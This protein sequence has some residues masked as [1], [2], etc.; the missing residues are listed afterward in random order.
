MGRGCVRAL[1]GVACDERRDCVFYQA[2]IGEVINA[3]SVKDQLFE[4]YGTDDPVQVAELML[5]ELRVSVYGCVPSPPNVHCLRVHRPPDHATRCPLCTGRHSQ[6]SLVRGP[7]GVLRRCLRCCFVSRA[8]VFAVSCGVAC[9]SRLSLC[10][11]SDVVVVLAVVVA[12]GCLN[13]IPPMSV[14]L[15]FS[16]LAGINMVFLVIIGVVIMTI[17]SSGDTISAGLKWQIFKYCKALGTLPCLSVFV[18]RLCASDCLHVV[19]GAVNCGKRHAEYM[20]GRGLLYIYVGATC[21]LGPIEH[22]L[23]WYFLIIGIM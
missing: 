10:Y 12:S 18:V 14:F 22:A 20:W 9:A 1:L 15:L 5:T 23:G 4:H 2:N 8:H 3:G 7:F 16:P 11:C 13:L 19:P 6:G 17:E 21:I